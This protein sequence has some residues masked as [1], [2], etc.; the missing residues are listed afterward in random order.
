MSILHGIK[1]IDT[2]DNVVAFKN[3]DGAPKISAKPYYADISK[4][5]V[6]NHTAWS[7]MGYNGALP[8][9]VEVDLA[10]YTSASYIFPA[11]AQSM[12]IVSTSIYDGAT[13]AGIQSVRVYYLNAAYA[14]ASVNV[15]LAGTTSVNV[16]VG[17]IFRVQNI[18]ASAVGSSGSAVGNITLKN[19]ANLLTYGAI[20]SGYTRQRQLTWTVPANKVLF[21]TSGV[22]ST[23]SGAKQAQVKFTLRATFDEKLGTTLTPGTFF[24]PYEEQILQDNSLVHPL[25]MPAKF[26]AQTDIKVSVKGDQAGAQANCILDG[27]TEPA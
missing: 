6:P 1:F 8:A 20:W 24:M 3:I 17:D 16:G 22:M 27:W 19:Q 21:I 12:S 13:S 25:A 2:S 14:E 15:S 9:N 7:K 10:P 26:P 11:A 23:V 4:G 18:R 5:N